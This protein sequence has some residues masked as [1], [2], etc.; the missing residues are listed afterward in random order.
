M[1]KNFR[2]NKRRVKNEFR[3]CIKKTWTETYEW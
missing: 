2:Q 3:E 1:R